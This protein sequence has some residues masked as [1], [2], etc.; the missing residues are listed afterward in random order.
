MNNKIPG[1]YAGS[2][3]DFNC[4]EKSVEVIRLAENCGD[5]YVFQSINQSIVQSSLDVLKIEKYK[6]KTLLMFKSIH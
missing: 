2:Q 6:Q 1:K 5:F 3:L 4:V